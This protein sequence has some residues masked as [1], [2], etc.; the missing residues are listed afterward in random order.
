[1]SAN[2]IPSNPDQPDLG[3]GGVFRSSALLVAVALVTWMAM[4]IGFLGLKMLMQQ[5]P[6][7]AGQPMRF[8]KAEL[9]Q[10]S[11]QVVMRNNCPN[12]LPMP[13]H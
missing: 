1:M 9:V 3:S 4:A 11:P 13:G 5:R 7:F 6:Q 2:E 12:E 10:E 8:S